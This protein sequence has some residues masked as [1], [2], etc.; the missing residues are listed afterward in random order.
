[1]KMLI[2][3]LDGLGFESLNAMGMPRLTALIDKGITERPEIDNVV[4]RGW[5]ELYSGLSAYETGAFY[6]IPVVRNG[7]IRPTQKTGADMVE[8][9]VGS[10]RLLWKRLTTEGYKVGL[11]TLPTVSTPQENCEI[12][13]PASGAG[14]FGSHLLS[15]GTRPWYIDHL[16]MFPSQNLGFRIGRG[17]FTPDSIDE[18]EKWLRDHMAQYFSVL[19]QLY[20]RDDVDVH[21]VG[22]RFFTLYYKFRH[23]I[24]SESC[25]GVNLQLKNM[26]MEVF[27]DFDNELSSFISLLNPNHLFVVADHGLGKLNYHVNINELLRSVGEISYPSTPFRAARYAKLKFSQWRKFKEK[28][29]YVFPSF[30]FSNSKAFSIEY[31]DVIYINDARF[32]GPEM[33]SSERYEYAFELSRKLT[34]FAEDN[35]Y[36]QFKRF[37]PLSNEGVTCPV[38]TDAEAVALPD[39]RCHLA[40]GS[41]NLGQTFGSVIR[42]NE[43]YG[44]AEMFKRGFYAQHAGCKK[45]DTIASYI[46]PDNNLVE[47]DDLTKI[48]D[49]ILRVLRS[50]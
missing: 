29:G 3:G 14:V 23:I 46:G 6:Q 27:K 28:M 21:V 45:N 48:Y 1:M 17:A 39:I 30:D 26:L 36:N 25:E 35:G 15:E 18:L 42:K 50:E 9:H 47:L 16:T 11:F 4:S 20:Y 10:E 24:L 43:P 31:T 13:F 2:L 7:K 5:P 38:Q 33:S 49:S 40:E 22:S 34:E 12:Y 32:F 41:V 19:R 8:R 37:E 44:A